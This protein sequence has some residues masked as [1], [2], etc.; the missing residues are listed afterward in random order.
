MTRQ[1]TDKLLLRYVKQA[2]RFGMYVSFALL[3]IGVVIYLTLDGDAG[4]V[5]GP[6]D[7]IESALSLE[8]QG[9]LSL[10]IISLILTPLLG[11]TAA[12]VVFV[13]AKEQRMAGVALLVIGVVALAIMV[14]LIV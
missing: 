4:K 7:A 6:I 3:L 14:K 1:E 2:L 8:A 9:W 11:I 10:G 13:R 5:L 12:L